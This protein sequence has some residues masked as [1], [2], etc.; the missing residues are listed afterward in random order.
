M[1]HN[2]SVHPLIPKACQYI[3]EH[4]QDKITMADLAQ[5]TNYSERSIQLIFQST[6]NNRHLSILTK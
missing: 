1:E 3:E 2:V 6:L 5:Y 4:H